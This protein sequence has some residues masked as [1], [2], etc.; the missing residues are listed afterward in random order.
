MRSRFVRVV[1]DAER[2]WKATFEM[3]AQNAIGRDAEFERRFRRRRRRR[4]GRVSSR[5]PGR[6]RFR[7]GRVR[8][9]VRL[10]DTLTRQ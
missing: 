7:R 8:L 3:A 5:E 6:R 1:S 4:L 10:T 9:H 2:H